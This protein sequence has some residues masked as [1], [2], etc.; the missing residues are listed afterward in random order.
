MCCGENGESNIIIASLV[1]EVIFSAC[2]AKFLVSS[3]I[4]ILESTCFL[5]FILIQ[6]YLCQLCQN[7]CL[8]QLHLPVSLTQSL[9]VSSIRNTYK[10]GMSTF[11]PFGDKKLLH[12]SSNLSSPL[13]WWPL[14]WWFFFIV[15]TLLT[16]CTTNLLISSPSLNLA[17]WGFMPFKSSAK[18]P[19]VNGWMYSFCYVLYCLKALMYSALVQDEPVA[20]CWSSPAGLSLAGN[21]SAALTSKGI[22]LSFTS[23]RLTHAI[24]LAG[25]PAVFAA[26]ID[27]SNASSQ[28]WSNCVSIS[29]ARA[30]P[31]RPRQNE[32]CP[33]SRQISSVCR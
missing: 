9:A 20:F 16:T 33:G 2:S 32:R 1:L 30:R 3:L 17:K 10:K 23:M 28:W 27:S 21:V 4:S 24:W 12:V 13:E 29:N 19:L 6:L 26:A 8:H 5:F 14:C 22:T 7:Q 15:S 18:S 11:L 31:Y 25:M